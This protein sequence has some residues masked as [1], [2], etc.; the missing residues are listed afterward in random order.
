MRRGNPSPGKLG[1][2]GAGTLY[3]HGDS[4]TFGT[5]SGKVTALFRGADRPAVEKRLAALGLE[6]K[7]LGGQG[8]GD[9]EDTAPVAVVLWHKKDSLGALHMLDEIAKTEGL[10]SVSPEVLMPKSKR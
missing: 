3:E 6:M 9:E 7:E 4:G 5:P 1:E 8:K 10:E 2:P